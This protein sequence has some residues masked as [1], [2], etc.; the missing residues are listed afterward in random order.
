MYAAGLM[1]FRRDL[2]AVD[3]AALHH[4]LRACERL[5]CAFVFDTAILDALPRADRRVEFI[6]ESV[7]ELDAT[8]RELGGTGCGLLVAH[9][10]APSEVPAL[11]A[12]LGVQAVFANHDHE[13][14]ACERDETVA[15]ALRQA[16]IAFHTFKDQTVFERDEVVTQAGTPYTVFTPYS[17]AWL[18]KVDAQDL[19]AFDTGSL[20][21]KLAARPPGWQRAVPSLADLGF[22]ATNLQA[23]GIAPG[24]AGAA[25]TLAAFLPRLDRYQAQRDARPATWAC[26]CASAP[27][28]SVNWCGWPWRVHPRAKAPRLG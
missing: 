24:A 26:I 3:N 7:A 25:Q 12:V 14:V 1:W 22:T 13:A 18:A 6:R 23:L 19:Q 28:P 20:P 9:G 21:H 11:A 17:R 2:R 16:G 5:H 27:F 8:L 10:P 15:H 4:A